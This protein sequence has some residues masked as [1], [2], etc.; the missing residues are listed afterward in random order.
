[1]RRAPSHAFTLIET[2]GCLGLMSLMLGGGL[3]IWQQTRQATL[4]QQ[5]RVQMATLAAQI[6]SLRLRDGALPPTLPIRFNPEDAWGTPMAYVP[7]GDGFTLVSV[8]ADGIA[9][10]DDIIYDSQTD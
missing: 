1:M 8:A 9:S 2:L 3:V 6:N 4:R 10:S 7:A 5:T